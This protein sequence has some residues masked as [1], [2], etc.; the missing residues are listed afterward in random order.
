MEPHEV[1]EYDWENTAPGGNMYNC[2]TATYYNTQNLI[3]MVNE[4]KATEAAQTEAI[5]ALA[6]MHGADFA[7]V[8]QAVSD[9]V[10]KKLESIKLN[11]STE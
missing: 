6:E 3:N 11:V 7:A 8:A 4:L 5:K 2:A 1:W 10:T 9:A